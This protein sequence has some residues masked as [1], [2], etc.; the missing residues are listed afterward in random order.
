MLFT[1]ILPGWEGF[2]TD[3]QV[4][5]DAL[6]KGFSV[7]AGFY[8]LADAGFPH[9][10]ELLVLFCGVQYYLQEWGAAGVRYVFAI[11]SIYY[12]TYSHSAVNAKELFNLHHAQACNV[13]ERIF[14]VLKQCFRI[15]LLLPCYPLDFQ[16]CI[17]VALCAPQNFIQEI[18]QDEGEIQIYIRQLM[19]F[20]SDVDS[21]YNGGFITD[22][23]EENSEV[24]LHRMNIANEMWESYLQ[25]TADA[26]NDDAFS[27]QE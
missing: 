18:D 14:G 17:P 2:A 16:P 24:K 11:I 23:D 20:P 22:D 26:D 27:S 7:P 9:C 3:A 1:Y 4:W 13:I 12:L 10:P 21:N 5:A 8:Y 25:Y 15:L 19:S 6:A